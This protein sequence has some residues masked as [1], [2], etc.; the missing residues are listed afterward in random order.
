MGELR[1]ASR[2]GKIALG[3]RHA[4]P[5][6]PALPL[7]RAYPCRRNARGERR[8]RGGRDKERAVP[9]LELDAA[10]DR[11]QDAEPVGREP[12]WVPPDLGVRAE[13]VAAATRTGAPA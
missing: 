13:G 2:A 11:R 6:G 10:G 1:S 3:E 12:G 5:A 4:S 7:R 8:R 9:R